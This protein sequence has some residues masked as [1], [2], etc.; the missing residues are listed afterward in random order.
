MKKFPYSN[1]LVIRISLKKCKHE[2]N[3]LHQDDKN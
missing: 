3:L 1:K 2:V